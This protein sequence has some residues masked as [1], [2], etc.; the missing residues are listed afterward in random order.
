PVITMLGKVDIR[1][2]VYEPEE[3]GA[4]GSV[5]TRNARVRTLELPLFRR[6]DPPSHQALQGGRHKSDR[7]EDEG[8][9]QQDDVVRGEAPDNQRGGPEEQAREQR[10]A[11][12][13]SRDE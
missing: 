9:E 7:C 10:F 4:D 5:E 12:A 6:A 3:N 8:G 11:F 13:E 1:Q 2:R